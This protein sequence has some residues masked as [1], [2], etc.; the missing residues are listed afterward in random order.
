MK[1]IRVK[2]GI[3]NRS[4]RVTSKLVCTHHI[5]NIVIN[6]IQ[7]CESLGLHQNKAPSQ[8]QTNCIGLSVLHFLADGP[9]Q[10]FAAPES[11]RFQK[12]VRPRHQHRAAVAGSG[13]LRCCWYSIEEHLGLV[14]DDGSAPLGHHAGKMSGFFDCCWVHIGVLLLLPSF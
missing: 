14:R 12:W 4:T 7:R 11:S 1:G 5:F 2:K 9:F 8:E 6:P 3:R 13:S 10:R